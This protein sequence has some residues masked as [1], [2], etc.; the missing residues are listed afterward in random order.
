MSYSPTV[1][2]SQVQHAVDLTHEFTLVSPTW[3]VEARARSPGP[4]VD[5][6]APLRRH[7]GAESLR[8]VP[9]ALHRGSQTVQERSK[10]AS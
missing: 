2:E 8:L 5:K 6:I 7:H 9:E 4:Q 1:C 3:P 10:T